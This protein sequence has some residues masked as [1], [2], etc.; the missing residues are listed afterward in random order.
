M[1]ILS[2]PELKVYLGTDRVDDD[3]FLE[4]SRVAA[5]NAVQHA[6]QRPFEVASDASDRMYVPRLDRV[7]FHDCTSVTSITANDEAVSSDDYQLEPLNGLSWS[8]Q[9]RPYE[10]ARLH[11]G[12]W[13]SDGERATITVTATWG[14]AAIPDEVKAATLIVAKD[15][16][17]NKDVSFGIAAFTEYAAIRVRENPTVGAL[18]HSFRR[19][20]AIGIA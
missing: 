3:D 2:L 12:C 13:Y 18:L 17:K 16:V 19:V 15:V 4:V 1:A 10:Q 14:W 6:C 9:A 7:R 20:E 11:S 5:E 8:G